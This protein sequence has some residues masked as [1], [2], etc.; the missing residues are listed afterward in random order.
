[1]TGSKHAGRMLFL[2][3]GGAFDRRPGTWGLEAHHEKE[4]IDMNIE[5]AVQQAAHASDTELREAYTVALAYGGR[6]TGCTSE[7]ECLYGMLRLMTLAILRLP[8]LAM[9]AQLM[10]I[11]DDDRAV[12]SVGHEVAAGALRLAHRALQTHGRDVGYEIGAWTDEA[13]LTAAVELAREHDEVPVA[14]EQVRL[15]TIALTEAAATVF[16]DRMLVPERLARG[17][18]HLLAFYVIARRM[19][20]AHQ[21]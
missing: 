5:Q 9:I 12:L 6:N 1:L 3:S 20:E 13:L 21:R 7:E 18:S 11:D 15:A 8:D 17:L 14:I 10:H 4:A 19:G 16:E 2:R